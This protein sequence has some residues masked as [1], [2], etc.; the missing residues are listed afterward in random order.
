MEKN[1]G[2]AVDQV[3]PGVSGTIPLSPFF[4]WPRKDAWE[5]LRLMLESKPWVSQKQMIILLNHATDIINLWQE[6]GGELV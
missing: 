6:S 4:F 3:I 5:E 1:L 2:L